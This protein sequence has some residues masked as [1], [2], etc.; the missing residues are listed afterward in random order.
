[1]KIGKFFA[2]IVL[3]FVS[4]SYFDKETPRVEFKN[5]EIIF[6]NLTY[7]YG[8]SGMN[9]LTTN[10]RDFNKIVWDDLRGLNGTYS[11]YRIYFGKDQYGNE[12]SEKIP[13]GVINLTELN[14]YQSLD[15][16]I[17]DG[18]AAKMLPGVKFY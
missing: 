16:F 14:K 7:K 4:C 8:I 13:L 2:F 17:N 5:N 12:N 15:D 10:I 18:G 6:H 9:E 3:L 1:M 11:A